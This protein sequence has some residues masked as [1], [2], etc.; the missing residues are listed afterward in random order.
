MPE[1]NMVELKKIINNVQDYVEKEKFAY[2]IPEHLFFILLDD[3]KCQEMIKELSEN[4]DMVDQLKLV[5]E[6][7]LHKMVETTSDISNITPT[8]AYSKIIQNT[9]AQSAMRSL[10]PTS[11]NL[12]S[13]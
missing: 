5:T 3:K 9:V 7:Y 11:L 13:N 1:E 12:F 8:S 4:K 10:P 2:I 6:I